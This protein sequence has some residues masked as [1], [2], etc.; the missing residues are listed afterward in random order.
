MIRLRQCHLAMPL[1]RSLGHVLVN[2]SINIPPLRGLGKPTTPLSP[3]FLQKGE[4]RNALSLVH[5][6]QCA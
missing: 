3:T 4:E 5:A 2:V 6:R 1:L